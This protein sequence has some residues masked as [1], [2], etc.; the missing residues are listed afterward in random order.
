MARSS[1]TMGSAEPLVIKGENEDAMG[2][3]SQQQQQQQQQQQ[4]HH[5]QLHLHTPLARVASVPPPSSR[6]Q[7]LFEQWRGQDIDVHNVDG[8]A[9]MMPPPSQHQS[10]GFAFTMPPPPTT[11]TPMNSGRLPSSGS[12]SAS[13]MWDDPFPPASPSPPSMS[14]RLSAR[15][16]SSCPPLP[17]PGM[18]T[19]FPFNNATPWNSMASSFANACSELD[20]DVYQSPSEPESPSPLPFRNPFSST[21][22][23]VSSSVPGPTVSGSDPY[24]APSTPSTPPPPF[25]NPF[26]SSSSP[27]AYVYPMGYASGDVQGGR[28]ARHDGETPD[29]QHRPM[30]THHHHLQYEDPR[31]LTAPDEHRPFTA[32]ESNNNFSTPRHY[33]HGHGLGGH[34]YGDASSRLMHRRGSSL[35]RAIAS[36]SIAGA[37]GGGS[38]SRSSFGLGMGY[39][40]GH[41]HGHGYAH[42][43]A[44]ANPSWGSDVHDGETR[45]ASYAANANAQVRFRAKSWEMKLTCFCFSI[46]STSHME[47]TQRR[48]AM[49]HSARLAQEPRHSRRRRL[50]H[51]RRALSRHR[52]RCR[53]RHQQ[54]YITCRMIPP[55]WVTR[56]SST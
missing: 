41:G 25:T 43:H 1:S 40:H 15:R 42:V 51:L 8:D 13:Y 38:L 39:G 4:L 35:D 50:P 55:H 37:M 47:E 54:G 12:S 32:P 17:P 2:Y 16:S 45:E 19:S 3:P 22:S 9:E 18:F 30:R 24:R 49:L 44:Q 28:A 23:S 29:G 34:G 48:P 14:L 31:P 53:L 7:G 5:G 21:A 36:S 56:V 11:P 27:F 52:R 26:M 33:M 6:P 46:S 20:P 10:H